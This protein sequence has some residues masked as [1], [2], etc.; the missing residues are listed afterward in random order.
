MDISKII[1]GVASD[2]EISEMERKLAEMKRLREDAAKV[3]AA[4]MKYESAL[5]VLG[6]DDLLRLMRR[7][8]AKLSDGHRKVRG[9]RVSGDLKRSLVEALQTGCYTL[10]QLESMFNLSKSY[11]SRVRKE[12]SDSGKLHPVMNAYEDR[13]LNLAPS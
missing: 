4:A 13:Q 6:R 9:S 3:V 1:N 10:S 12:L 11:I 5:D 7:I 2:E 8:Q